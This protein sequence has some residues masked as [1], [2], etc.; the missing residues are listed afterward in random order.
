MRAGDI[1]EIYMDPITKRDFECYAQLVSFVE[2][3][4]DMPLEKWEVYLET[5]IIADRNIR[6]E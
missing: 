3:I 5:G 6:R 4:D 1:I 2:Y